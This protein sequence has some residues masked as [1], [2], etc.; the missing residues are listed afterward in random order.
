MEQLLKQKKLLILA[1]LE[2]SYTMCSGDMMGLIV[3]CMHIHTVA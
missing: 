1:S 3:F 2:M